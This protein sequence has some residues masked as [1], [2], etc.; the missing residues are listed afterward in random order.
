MSCLGLH[1][2]NGIQLWHWVVKLGI[3]VLVEVMLEVK[4]RVKGELLE[5]GLKW[6][7]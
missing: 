1:R 7:G 4:V 2:V 5:R 6:Q 3:Q